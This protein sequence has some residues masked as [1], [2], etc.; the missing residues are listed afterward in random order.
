M[1]TDAL[2]YRRKRG[3]TQKKA[4]KIAREGLGS[5][6]NGFHS[7]KQKNFIGLIAGGGTPTRLKKRKNRRRV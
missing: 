7:D 1:P 6:G 2:S 5:A 3:L 4:K